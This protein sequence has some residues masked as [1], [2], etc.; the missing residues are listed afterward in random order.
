MPVAVTPLPGVG[1]V[2]CVVTQVPEVVGEPPVRRE[3]HDRRLPF[4]G[5]RAAAAGTSPLVGWRAGIAV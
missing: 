3:L 1:M 5:P 2:K 4:P